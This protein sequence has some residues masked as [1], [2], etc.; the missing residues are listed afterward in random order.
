MNAAS[1]SFNQLLPTSAAASADG[2]GSDL[3]AYI[4]RIQLNNLDFKLYNAQPQDSTVQSL[5]SVFEKALCGDGGSM[6]SH[7]ECH[8]MPGCVRLILTTYA[9]RGTLTLNPKP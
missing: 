4:A 9:E 3:R 1:S 5:W 7:T 2:V 6:P 8:V